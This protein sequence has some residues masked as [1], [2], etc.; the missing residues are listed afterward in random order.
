VARDPYFNRFNF[1]LRLKK[2]TL[3]SLL[4]NWVNF[5]EIKGINGTVNQ[6]GFVVG[7]FG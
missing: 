3:I 2:D 5:S 6:E 1:L 7:M 4:L